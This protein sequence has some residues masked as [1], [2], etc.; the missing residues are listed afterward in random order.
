MNKKIVVIILGNRLNDDGSLSTIGKE[1]LKLASEIEQTFHP[2]YYI[3][4]GGLANEKAGITEAEA[5]YNY[6]LEKHQNV[7]GFNKDK[8]ILEKESL[9][10]VGNAKYSVPLAK[11]LGAEIIIVCSSAYHFGDPV[12]KAM[13][14]FVNELKNSNIVLMTYCK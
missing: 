11:E 7:P 1:R 2:D 12:Y 10:T 8:F 14:S 13:E 9:S 4:S 6:L 3:L 5:M